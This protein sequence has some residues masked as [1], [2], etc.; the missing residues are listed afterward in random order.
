MEVAGSGRLP[1]QGS[2]WGGETGRNPTDRGKSG[3]KKSIVSEGNG[4]PVGATIAGANVHDTKLLAATLEA[5]VVEPPDVEQHLCLD[6][7]YNNPTGRRTVEESGHVAHIA[8]TD[9]GEKRRS[10]SAK[11]RRWVVERAFAWLQKCRGLLIRYDKKASNYLALLQLGCALLWIR[12][13]HQL[14]GL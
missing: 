10:A 5:V 13:L 1:G 9:S 2:F 6:R 11:P 3:T 4:Y 14:G 8:G 12:R 7:G